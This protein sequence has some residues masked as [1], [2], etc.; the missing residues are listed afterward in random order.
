MAPC[1]SGQQRCYTAQLYMAPTATTSVR[2]L[3]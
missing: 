1:K 2:I 3:Y